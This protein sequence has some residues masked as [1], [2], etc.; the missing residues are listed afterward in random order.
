MV[1]VDLQVA[2]H[3][4]YLRTPSRA[5]PL[6]YLCL[7]AHLPPVWGPVLAELCEGLLSLSIVHLR[8]T[9]VVA[10]VSAE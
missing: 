10:G 8:S 3:S 9:C 4:R 5:L 7:P 1:L 6:R 2:D